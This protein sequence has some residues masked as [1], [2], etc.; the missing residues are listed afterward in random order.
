MALPKYVLRA[1]AA[2]T[3]AENTQMAKPLARRNRRR[4]ARSF[5]RLADLS[6]RAHNVCRE[7]RFCRWSVDD[8]YDIQKW[9]GRQA[10]WWSK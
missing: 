7:G 4:V 3:K 2:A 9:A 6:A 8:A 5:E 1:L 10:E